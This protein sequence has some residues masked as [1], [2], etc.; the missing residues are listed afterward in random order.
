M[1]L[2]ITCPSQAESYQPKADLR[3]I[4]IFH[5]LQS[6]YFKTTELNDNTG[7]TGGDHQGI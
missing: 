7:N 6:I 1:N 5:D 3:E 2:R 4:L